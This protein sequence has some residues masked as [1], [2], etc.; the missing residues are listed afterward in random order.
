MRLRSAVLVLGLVLLAPGSRTAPIASRL[1]PAT[2]VAPVAA[3]G[4][5]AV[6]R[7]SPTR[8]PAPALFDDKDVMLGLLFLLG[9]QHGHTR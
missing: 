2:A 3:E 6:K 4:A 7:Q 8:T 5:V 9:I 1:A